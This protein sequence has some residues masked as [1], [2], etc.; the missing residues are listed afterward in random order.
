MPRG[1]SSFPKARSISPLPLCTSRDDAK[2]AISPT[3]RRTRIREKAEKPHFRGREVNDK[4]Y[5]R[6]GLRI[7][8]RR[9][10]DVAYI[11]H[12]AVTLVVVSGVESITLPPES[13]EHSPTKAASSPLVSAFP[14][15]RLPLQRAFPPCARYLGQ[16][17]R[18]Y[19]R[20]CPKHPQSSAPDSPPPP[21]RR[22]CPANIA[23]VVPP[24][25]G[26]PAPGA[27]RRLPS[28]RP[29]SHPRRPRS[30]PPP[31]NGPRKTERCQRRDVCTGCKEMLEGVGGELSLCHAASHRWNT[32]FPTPRSWD[33][34]WQRSFGSP[35]EGILGNL[36]IPLAKHADSRQFRSMSSQKYW[37]SQILT[38]VD[39][40]LS[41][42]L[43]T[44]YICAAEILYQID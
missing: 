14:R 10:C 40:E 3:W 20:P 35:S 29:F 13:G 21:W 24:S 36:L 39:Y 43:F 42:R 2:R 15:R 34:V 31:V 30:R 41:R 7:A 8:T 26:R 12:Q 16:V 1:Y 23:V 4:Q 22:F 11:S 6:S 9:N 37:L 28:R 33:F 38:T 18:K 32:H 27:R 17:P 44:C 25:L 19:G 5:L